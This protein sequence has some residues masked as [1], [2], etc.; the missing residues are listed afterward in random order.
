MTKSKREKEELMQE[1]HCQN[2]NAMVNPVAMRSNILDVPESR[3]QVQIFSH[4]LIMFLGII[5]TKLNLVTEICV[6]Q[7]HITCMYL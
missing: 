3:L 5:N 6:S 2:N 1:T 4:E 7:T